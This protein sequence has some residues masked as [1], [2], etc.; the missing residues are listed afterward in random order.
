MSKLL[1]A[2]TL[3]LKATRSPCPVSINNLSAKPPPTSVSCALPNLIRPRVSATRVRKSAARP[4]RQVSNVNCQY[5]RQRQKRCPPSPSRT[6]T[7]TDPGYRCTPT[8]HC[9]P[10]STPYFRPSQRRRSRCH[11]RLRLNHGSRP[12][13]PGR[14]KN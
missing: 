11:A 13:R 2:L 5:Q 10:F 7:Q 4:E 14:R 9:E 3:R 12:T 8:A 6:C 1:K